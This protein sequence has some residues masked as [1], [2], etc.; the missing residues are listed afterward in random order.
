[1]GSIMSIPPHAK[2]VFQGTIFDVYQWNQKNFDGSMAI[3]EMLKR[4]NTLEVIPVEGQRIVIAQ[5]E[6]PS[7][8]KIL[9]L[10]GGRQEPDESP[11]D[12]VKREL[13]EETG[14]VSDDWELWMTD[15]P[16]TKID[17]TVYTYIARNCKTA[18]NPAPDPG[19]KITLL[20]LTFDEFIET[21]STMKG[22]SEEILRMKL[23][24]STLA[25]FRKKLLL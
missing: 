24:P 17:W 5:D 15:V 22:L 19:E 4:P 23:N 12:G 7:R 11:M 25:D 21:A 9:K 20:R 2:R 8:P 16:T 6:Q 14:L 3:F 10:P 1:M 13:F 18:G